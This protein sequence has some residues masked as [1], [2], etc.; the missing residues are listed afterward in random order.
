MNLS[1]LGY[2]PSRPQLVAQ[3]VEDRAV[4]DAHPDRAGKDTRS[5]EEYLAALE[6]ETEA[7]LRREPGRVA[8]GARMDSNGMGIR[9]ALPAHREVTAT[10]RP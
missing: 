7:W 10:D 9:A 5:P 1:G 8:W 4:A 6:R 3:A 2:Y